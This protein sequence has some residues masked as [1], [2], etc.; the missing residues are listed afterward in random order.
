MVRSATRWGLTGTILWGASADARNATRCGTGAGSLTSY[1]DNTLGP[2]LLKASTAANACAETRCSG[3]GR[4][5]GAAGG[6]ACD[7]DKGSSE[8]N[9]SKAAYSYHSNGS[10][11]QL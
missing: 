6:E 5:W 1:I 4:C 11:I 10:R 8:A 2:A 9:C 7:C 3:R